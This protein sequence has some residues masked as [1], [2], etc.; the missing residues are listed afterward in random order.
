MAYE[1][2]CDNAV[3]NA[4]LERGDHGRPSLSPKRH[5]YCGRCKTLVEAVEEQ[6]RREVTAKAL[7][8]AAEVEETRQ[9]LMREM[10]P[11]QTSDDQTPRQGLSE[12]P[13]IG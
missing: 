10:W 3:C 11:I 13:R 8:L 7:T 5:I 9:R 2:R 6:V 1:L 12:Y 4:V